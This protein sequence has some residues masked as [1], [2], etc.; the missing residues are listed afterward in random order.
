MHHA[1]EFNPLGRELVH[2]ICGSKLNGT[3]L[4]LAGD[5]DEV[6]TLVLGM[7]GNM[8]SVLVCW[9]QLL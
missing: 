1:G 5:P 3:A 9:E 4:A 7:A 6:S 2:E 8:T